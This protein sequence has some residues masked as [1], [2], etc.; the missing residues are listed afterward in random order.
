MKSSSFP[1]LLTGCLLGFSGLWLG[2]CATTSP[3]EQ[4]TPEGLVLLPKTRAD[5]VWK[6]PDAD[7]SGYDQILLAPPRIAF[8]KYW[9]HD[10][11]YGRNAIHSRVNDEDMAKIIAEGKMLLTE[12]FTAELTK[13]GFGIATT[14]GP[15]VLEVEASIIDLDILAPDPNNVSGYWTRTYTQ[16]SGAARLQLELRD[17]VTGQLLVRASDYK[18]NENDQMTWRIPRTQAAN[19]QDARAA[20]HD[21]ARMLVHGLQ[22]A[23][24]AAKP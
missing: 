9:Q 17:S 14:P 19:R 1:R 16:G 4:V 13:A 21:W 3:V 18:N 15:K 22:K 23:Q 5:H 11:N 8:R 6:L 20:L 7:L 10:V 2:G 24:A 12:Q